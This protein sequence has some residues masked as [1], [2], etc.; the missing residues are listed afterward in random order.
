MIGL[1]VKDKKL[2]ENHIYKNDAGNQKLQHNNVIK[3]NLLYDETDIITGLEC[4]CN[5]FNININNNI[6][7]F[8]F[9]SFKR[10]G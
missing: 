2:V 10:K 4:F 6:N 7:Y 3:N 8:G 9:F 5:R 1:I